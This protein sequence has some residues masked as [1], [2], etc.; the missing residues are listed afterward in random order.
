M[1]YALIS[2]SIMCLHDQGDSMLNNSIR[3]LR[4]AHD[5]VEQGIVGGDS[6]DS[7]VTVHVTIYGVDG[8]ELCDN[9]ELC[10]WVRRDWRH[11][12]LGKRWWRPSS[13]M[14]RSGI[15]FAAVDSY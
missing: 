6:P 4:R 8:G 15:Y 1:L 5:G 7:G 10:F 13:L 14:W 11:D 3:R 12:N 9:F 2:A